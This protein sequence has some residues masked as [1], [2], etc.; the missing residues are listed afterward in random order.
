M[1]PW[2]LGNLFG[3]SSVRRLL[4][5]ADGE[6]HR[7]RWDAA[8]P[9]YSEAWQQ[10]NQARALGT[11]DPAGEA[12]ALAGLVGVSRRRGDLAAALTHCRQAR[13]LNL[14]CA[15]F[16]EFLCEQFAADG[17]T[18]PL[19]DDLLLWAEDAEGSRPVEDC[20]RK[21]LR[22]GPAGSAA[23]VGR[24]LARVAVA[25]PGWAW[26]WLYRAEL[27]RQNGDWAHAAECLQGAIE[28]TAR[29][30]ARTRL[31]WHLARSLDAAGRADAAFAVCDDAL[32]D[33]PPQ[34]PEQ[35][36][37]VVR[38]DLAAGR[39]SRA[40]ERVRAGL[41]AH[42]GRPE[43][44]V[45]L[46][47]C[48]RRGDVQSVARLAWVSQDVS[49]RQACGAA[50]L[51]LA[52][53][54]WN[55]SLAHTPERLESLSKLLAGAVAFGQPLPTALRLW[56]AALQVL[57]GREVP[58]GEELPS[59]DCP[60]SLLPL[61]AWLAFVRGEPGRDDLLMRAWQQAPDNP[62]LPWLLRRKAHELVTAGDHGAAARLLGVSAGL[63][64][65]RALGAPD[66]LAHWHEAWAALERG[67]HSAAL[68]GCLEAVRSCDQIPGGLVHLALNVVSRAGDPADDV[69]A[70][71]LAA[72]QER[73]EPAVSL[74]WP[75]LLRQGK[76]RAAREA[77]RQRLEGGTDPAALHAFA[78]AGM[79]LARQAAEQGDRA[80]AL[81]DLCASLGAWAALL[82]ETEALACFAAARY[83]R[84]GHGA[85]PPDGDRCRTLLAGL[86]DGL[87]QEFAALCGV[88]PAR[89]TL[90]WGLE[91]RALEVASEF[92]GRRAGPLLCDALGLHEEARAFATAGQREEE[93]QA[94][95]GKKLL[96]LFGIDAGGGREEDAPPARASDRERRREIQRLFSPLGP[97]C[98]LLHTRQFS[99]V[100]GEV[101]R[102]A[103]AGGCPFL[104][105]LA[106]FTTD[107]DRTW[108]RREGSELLLE[109]HLQASREA[110]ARV[111]ANLAQVRQHWE[112]ALALA[113][114]VGNEADVRRCAGDIAAG[115]SRA[116]LAE[117]AGP[118]EGRDPRPDE[119]RRR[120]GL[121]LLELAWE[122]TGAGSAQAAL[123]HGLCR[124]AVAVF[125][126]F[127][128]HDAAAT[129]LVRALAVRPSDRDAA[130]LLGQLLSIRLREEFESDPDRAGQAVL[131]VLGRLRALDSGRS[132]GDIRRWM[133]QIAEQGAR[134][135]FERFEQARQEADWDRAAALMGWCLRLA[136]QPAK[137]RGGLRNLREQLLARAEQGD[138]RCRELL[139]SLPERPPPGPLGEADSPLLVPFR[140]L[141]NLPGGE[142]RDLCE[143]AFEAAQDGFAEQAVEMLGQAYRSAGRAAEGA[144]AL[145]QALNE[146]GRAWVQSREA[147]GDMDGMLAAN[148]R[149]KELL[150]HG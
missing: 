22:P 88:D 48:C 91:R 84:Y 14:G 62:L 73:G 10:L 61:R 98:L 69:R 146:L 112:A 131:D 78:V 141:D 135:F 44:L 40:L 128:D 139:A 127:Q 76:L 27:A 134:P 150:R 39:L 13:A 93:R 130:D 24:V 111:P 81:R 55:E 121:D 137:V 96:D 63:P 17:P 56:R 30:P 140:R 117:R 65:L 37:L 21:I 113:R 51:R 129:T 110:A 59:S 118:R 120:E 122:M 75:V 18:S 116:L 70:E 19:L 90:L 100:P 66:W 36:C 107:E 23:A 74:P 47:D 33:T 68:R 104:A 101:A 32:S 83:A 4:H 71:L 99:A 35:F 132:S 57:G 77:L 16:V 26:P 97:A 20:L 80:T 41:G 67:D 60:P 133:T 11:P 12:A 34:T 9:L 43:L 145:R 106:R 149:V 144:G 7:G 29:G 50:F 115:R 54:H 58:L 102:A 103:E 89:L 105:L 72:C 82:E 136:P 125:E 86:L 2:R 42:P 53:T 87:I 28:R 31:L 108:L 119:D 95:L 142:V 114:D 8:E 52:V 1:R 92:G 123:A 46:E 6:A 147:A 38:S 126:A 143:R 138:A 148:R 49:L 79:A 94:L 15:A 45:L 64:L 3:S 5:R 124:H 25:V 109:S 85:A